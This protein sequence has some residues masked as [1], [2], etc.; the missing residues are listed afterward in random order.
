M[1]KEEL[2]C[3]VQASV[4]Q[5]CQKRGYAAPV[6]VLIEVGVLKRRD[7]EEWRF[8]RIPCL[9]RVCACNLPTLSL[10]M[11]EIRDS[12]TAAGY[13]P[14]YSFYGQWGNKKRMVRRDRTVRVNALRFSKS[15]RPDIEKAY[16]THYVNLQRIEEL[17]EQKQ[18]TSIL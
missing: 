6:D 13:K 7:Y 8:G 4:Y 16:A 5:Q 14:S 11:S 10:I 9:E 3:K 1:D 18:A 2:C 17:K 15:G 12:A